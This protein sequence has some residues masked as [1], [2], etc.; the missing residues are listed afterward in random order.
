MGDLSR[1]Y[2]TFVEFDVPFCSLTYSNSPCTAA[3]SALTPRKCFNTLR[4]CQDVENFDP[5]P[6]TLRFGQNIRGLPKGQTIFPALVS[7]STSPAELNLAGIGGEGDRMSALGKRDVVTIKLKDFAY[8][9]TLTDK[10]QTERVTGAAQFDGVGYDPADKGH[11]FARLR[12]RWPFFVGAELRVREGVVGDVI[13]SMQ[14]RHYFIS[15]WDGPD[16]AG[17][18]TITAKDVFDLAEREKAQVPPASQ[19]QLLADIDDVATSFELEPVGIGSDYPA[20]GRVVVGR[21]VMTYTRSGDVMTLAARAVD[22]TELTSHTAGDTAQI[23]QRYE[24]QTA[25]EIITD[26]LTQADV[27]PAFLPTTEWDDEVERWMAG[28]SFTRTITK[29]TAVTKLI[30]EICQ[31]GLYVWWDKFESEVK[32]RVARPLDI[33]ESFGTITDDASILKG[34][35]DVKTATEMR[36][37][38]VLFYHGQIDPTESDNDGQNYSRVIVASPRDGSNYDVSAIKSIFSPWFGQAGNEAATRAISRRL[39]NRYIDPPKIITATVDVKDLDTVDIGE[40]IQVTSFVLTDAAGFEVPESMQVSS[41]ERSPTQVE[42]KSET[43]EFTQRYGFIT[44][45]SRADYDASTPVEISLGTYIIDDADTL[46]PDGTTPY[47]M[48]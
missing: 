9:D 15:K 42:F 12:E 6:L 21:E 24:D 2:L 37:D 17:N 44:E 31:H 48:F 11:F 30:G 33:G 5:A 7:V 32:L 36:I 41:S 25:A 14:T 39:S 26:L 40:L 38:T 8:H 46:F 19:G 45:N 22:G 18:V 27:D 43:Y 28:I 1:E 20:A 29:P 3:L 10:Y 34:A 47:L 4:T 35:I 16:A 23:C 13:S